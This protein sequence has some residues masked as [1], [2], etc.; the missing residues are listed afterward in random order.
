MT[1][2]SDHPHHA[3]RTPIPFDVTRYMHFI[4]DPS[5][6]DLQRRQMVEALWAIVLSFVDLGFGLHP[7]QQACGKLEEPLA[8]KSGTDSD[9]GKVT[10][11]SLTKTFNK[12]AGSARRRKR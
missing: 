12:A 5:L 8:N 7:A 11:Y 3:G 4:E 2:H 10:A 9:G 1:E 6:N